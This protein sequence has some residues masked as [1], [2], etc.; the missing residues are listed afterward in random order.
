MKIKWFSLI[1]L[2]GLALVLCYHFYKTS[3][4]GGFIGVDIFF[5]FSGYLV[6]ALF[7]DEYART[8]Q[9]DLL[10]FARRRLYRILPPLV[11]MVLLVMP[12]TLL[13]KRD[14]VA[15]IGH[16]IAAVFGFT[17]NIYE[18]LT[19]GNY[20]SQFIPHLFLHTWS[21]AIEVQFYLVWGLVLSF[22]SRKPLNVGQ[23]R[24]LIFFLSAILFGLTFLGLFVT[25]FFTTNYSS[26]Y[27]SSFFRSSS[28][29][30]GSF[31]ATLTGVEY[32]VKRFRKNVQQWPL[33]QVLATIGLSVSLLVFLALSLAFDQLVTY[34]FGFAL[35]S[36]FT[37]LLI[38]SLRVLHDKLPG[39]GEPA[40]IGHLADLSY[41]IYL[42]HWPLFVIFTP[43]MPKSLA[44]GLTLFLS[45][46]LAVVSFYLIEPWIKKGTAT[47][48]GLVLPAPRDKRV[49]FGILGTLLAITL[50][51]SVTAPR[52]S[53]F[54]T[55]LLVNGLHQANRSITQTHNL[56]VGDVDAVNS[57]LILGDSVTLNSSQALGTLLP[58]AELD[59]A[60]SRNFITAFETFQNRLDNDALAKTVVLAV[61]VNS[62]YNYEAE[63][64]PFIDDLPN[65][66]RLVI[67]TPYNTADGRVPGMRDYELSLEKSYPYLKVADWYRA[68]ADTPEIW[69]GT[70]G[71]HFSSSNTKGAELY[72]KTIREA[73]VAVAK[74][75]AKGDKN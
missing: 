29:F 74:K 50:G 47:V 28:L 37:G 58:E 18:L 40:I 23:F 34:L 32:T 36:L 52:L 20:E 25:S 73:I 33:R 61:G 62:V 35:T 22:F 6:T 66:H 71:V 24:G 69:A 7:I 70:D 45:V 15:D 12:L 3:L 54:E 1:R 9:I 10:G 26:L 19:G 48:F 39:V 5:T 57:V 43:L 46:L 63:I 13:V 16:Q 56:L 30:L 65:G 14:F 38:Y 42:F 60:I 75:P 27:F 72:A 68:A 11:L 31:F 4:P 21:L 2:F 64:Q 8:G 49:S 44:V 59:A 17:T 41:G 67:V 51:I 53:P 55:T